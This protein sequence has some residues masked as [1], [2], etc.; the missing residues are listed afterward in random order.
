MEMEEDDRFRK[1]VK[2]VAMSEEVQDDENMR[3][4]CLLC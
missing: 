4:T 1:G 2:G 3:R